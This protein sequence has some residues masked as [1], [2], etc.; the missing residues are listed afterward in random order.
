MQVW[1]NIIV[2]IHCKFFERLLKSHSHIHI[3]N[4]SDILTYSYL[5]NL[6]RFYL[7]LP[8][9]QFYTQHDYIKNESN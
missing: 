1:Y 7:F 4:V 5:I 8:N 3:I 9:Q 6:I 2:E